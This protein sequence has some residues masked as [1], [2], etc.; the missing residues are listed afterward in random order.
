[1]G[2]LY[3]LVRSA[4]ETNALLGLAGQNLWKDES[5]D[6]WIGDPPQFEWTKTYIELNPVIEGLAG[7]ASDWAWSNAARR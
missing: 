1:V 7:K 6:Q 4:R 5:F 3:V 2:A